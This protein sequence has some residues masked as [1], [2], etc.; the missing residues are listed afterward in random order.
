MVTGV[1]KGIGK[2]GG[3]CHVLQVLLVQQKME[4]PAQ[5]TRGVKYVC[6]K[7]KV[8]GLG[9]AMS[10]KASIVGESLDLVTLE[11]GRGW[12]AKTSSSLPGSGHAMVNEVRVGLHPRHFLLSR[13]IRLRAG[14]QGS[15]APCSDEPK[16]SLALRSASSSLLHYF[17][18][19]HSPQVTRHRSVHHN[20]CTGMTSRTK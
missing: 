15:G 13:A 9:R 7:G 16:S 1:E 19:S 6:K 2:G 10:K 17:S 3:N 12:L 14:P 8:T 11:R 20:G 4:R 18:C 5:R